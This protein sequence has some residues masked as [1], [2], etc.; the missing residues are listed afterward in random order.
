MKI[1]LVK[2]LESSFRA[3]RLTL[4]R[5]IRSYERVI[6]EFQKGHV[7]ISKKHI[8][9]VFDLLESDDD[10]G[11][12][13]L[14][15]AEKAERLDANDFDPDFIKLLRSDLRILR[16]IEDIWDGVRRDPKWLAFRDVLK[17]TKLRSAKLIIFTESKETAEYLAEKIAKEVEKDVLL[18]TGSSINRSEGRS[19]PILMRRHFILVM[20]SGF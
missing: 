2:R 16:Q 12:E 6:T 13:R 19:F 10:E 18:F 20:N 5:F 1:L 17:S 3:F 14:L 8:N 11:I 9:K 7:Y 4:A 15:E